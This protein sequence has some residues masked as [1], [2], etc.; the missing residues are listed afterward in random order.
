MSTYL[1]AVH[2]HA[3]PRRTFGCRALLVLCLLSLACGLS[4]ATASAKEPASLTVDAN[5]RL[6]LKPQE[7]SEVVI[8]PNGQL[9]AIARSNEK[10]T[11]VTVNHWPDMKLVRTIQPGNV[12][13]VQTV[14]WLDDSR[15][16]IGTAASIT[17]DSTG[18]AV[19]FPSMFI[20]PVGGGKASQ[21]PA[22]FLATIEGDPNHLLV[23]SCTRIVDGD[24]VLEIRKVATGPNSGPGELVIEAPDSHSTVLSDDKGRVRFAMGWSKDG[25]SRTWVSSADGK[26]W[27]LINE[28]AKTGISVYPMGAAA[29]GKSGYLQ[30]QRAEGTDAVE[31]YDFTTGQRT[32][33]FHDPGSDPQQLILAADTQ[34]PIGAWFEQTH[35]T[36]HFWNPQHPHALLLAEALPAFAGKRFTLT[37]ASLDSQ[38]AVLWAMDDRDAGGYFVYDRASGK[39]TRVASTHPWLE[40]SKMAGS[41]EVSILARDGLALK[42]ILTTPAGAAAKSLPMVVLVHGGPYDVADAWGFDSEVQILARQGFAVLQVNF[43]GSGGYGKAFVDKGMRQWGRAMQDDVTDATRWAIAEGVADP[44]RICIYGASYGGYAALMGAA[45]EPS[46]YR[47]AVGMAGIYDLQKMY[48]WDN[49]RRT[50][51]GKE[52]LHRAIGSDP[53][54]LA[55]SSPM[56]QAGRITANVLLA[57]GK[58]D[59]ISDIRFAKAMQKALGRARG[60]KAELIVYD[61]QG[62]GWTDAKTQEDFFARLLRFLHANLDAAPVA[63]AQAATD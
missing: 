22:N 19:A 50:D 30:S 1:L 44:A 23:S 9:L 12:G 46:L 15:L 13:A 60:Q 57:H 41:R 26:S 2:R 32:E 29:D 39:A 52:F 17:V 33:I 35:P 21:M 6:L 4:V 43:R 55:M 58:L 63:A 24:C 37:S 20:V 16:V 3:S 11:I 31:R 5:T 25:R 8:S 59:Q 54:E 51:L 40:P 47:C 61:W 10:T 49:L 45:K 34:E 56:Q 42:G 53:A 62:H 38:R 28:E 48:K 36:P 7:V 14:R 18:I 27:T